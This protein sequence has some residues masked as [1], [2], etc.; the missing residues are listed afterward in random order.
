M[1]QRVLLPILL[2]ARHVSGIMVPET[3]RASNKIGNKNLCCI[4]LAF[5][6]HILTTMHGQ[7]H[8]KF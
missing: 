4:S 6:F 3:C 5:Y 1:Q 2:L 8:I 7:I